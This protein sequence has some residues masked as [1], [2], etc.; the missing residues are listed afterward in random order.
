MRNEKISTHIVCSIT[1]S[2]KNPA[3]Y[4]I[5]WENM[6]EPHRPQITVWYSTEKM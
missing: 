5:M 3:V 1:F 6:V 2:K 4:E